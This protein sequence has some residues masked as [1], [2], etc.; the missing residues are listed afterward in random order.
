MPAGG[1]YRIARATRDDI[2][3]ILALQEEN[4]PERGGLLSVR[5]PLGWFEAALADMPLIV[6]HKD[7]RL[8][9]YL[10]ASSVASQAHIPIVQGMLRAYP[11]TPDAYIYGPVCVAA[12]QR[13]H[14][15]PAAMFAAQRALVGN[16]TCITFI[17]RDNAISLR[18]HAKIGLHEV[19]E[20]SHDGVMLVVVAYA[21]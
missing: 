2:P 16:R 20:Y 18:A 7:E 4:L 13:G 9:G 12:G 5:L 21:G 17:R 6:A 15:V 14:G 1:D 3:D 11:A 19:A 10:V 8:A